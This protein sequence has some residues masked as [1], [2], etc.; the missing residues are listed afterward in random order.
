[1]WAPRIAGAAPF[2][3]DARAVGL[4]ILP[5][6]SATQQS[7]VCSVRRMHDQVAECLGERFQEL[8]TAPSHFG[9]GPKG[10][11]SAA[12]ALAAAAGLMRLRSDAPE[13]FLALV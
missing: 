5:A 12:A 13:G 8:S 2:L 1:M 10:A 4:Q 9:V 3:D 11:S 6:S 7:T